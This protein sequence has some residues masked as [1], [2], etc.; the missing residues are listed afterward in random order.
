ML[1]QAI[2]LG[3]LFDSN[4]FEGTP[5]GNTSRLNVPCDQEFVDNPERHHRIGPLYRV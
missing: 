1:L 5:N 4:R 2:R 3:L